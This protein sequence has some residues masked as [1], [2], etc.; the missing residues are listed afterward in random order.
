MEGLK[1]VLCRVV[2]QAR[3]GVFPP[4]NSLA[5]QLLIG[6]R[7]CSYFAVWYLLQYWWASSV[8][9]RSKSDS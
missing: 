7:L 2:A 6:G 4:L 5:W 8:L 3:R 1:T 9:E